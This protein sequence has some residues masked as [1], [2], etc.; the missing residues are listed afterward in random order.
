MALK[1]NKWNTL[2]Y[3][4]TDEDQAAYLEACFDEAGDDPIFI[5]KA[6]D[7]IAKAKGMNDLMLDKVEPSFSSILKAMKALGIRLHAEAVTH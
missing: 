6:L 7:N 1:L 2:D 4:K 3:L 5:A